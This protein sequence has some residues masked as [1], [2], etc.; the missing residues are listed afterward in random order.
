MLLDPDAPNENLDN[1]INVLR[2]NTP[3]L[4]SIEDEF[5]DP[6]GF[7]CL[8]PVSQPTPP[9]YKRLIDFIGQITKSSS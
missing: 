6:E 5:L 4:Q 1:N 7:C 3:H 8:L 9:F 2:K